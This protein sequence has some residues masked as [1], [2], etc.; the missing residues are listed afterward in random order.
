MRLRLAAPAVLLS[1]AL[2]ACAPLQQVFQV[3]EVAVQSI[4][5]TSLTLPG[6]FGS[7]PVAQIRVG[8]RVTNPNPLPLRLANL[9]GS[10]VIDGAVVGDVNFPN[11]ALPARGSAEQVAD[12]TLPVSLTT[13]ASFLK[14][15][16]GQLVTY[17]VDGRFSADFGPL[18]LQNFGPYTLAQG[19]WKQDPILPF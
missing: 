12:L 17:R 19:Q 8:L 14:V 9:G 5:L 13:A 18:G 3:P 15:A 10:L 2:G 6:G 1:L 16:R 11:I 4:G 7:A